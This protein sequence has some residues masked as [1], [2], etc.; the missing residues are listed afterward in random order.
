MNVSSN[1]PGTEKREVYRGPLAG[2]F[3]G[4]FRLRPD[5]ITDWEPTLAPEPTNPHDPE[6]IAIKATR[7]GVTKHVGYIPRRETHRL[8]EQYDAGKTLHVSWAGT[9]HVL[10]R[11]GS[12]NPT[13]TVPLIS[14]YWLA[15]A[16]SKVSTQALRPPGTRRLVL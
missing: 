15:R 7:N 9:R 5:R 4:D 2:V 10:D 12:P 3:F 1:R 13:L 16:Q 6:A 14:V 8:H 11:Y